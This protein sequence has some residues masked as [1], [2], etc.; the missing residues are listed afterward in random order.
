MDKIRQTLGT[1]IHVSI[2][3]QLLEFLRRPNMS[4]S[5]KY[6][7]TRSKCNINSIE[8]VIDGDKYSEILNGF[9]KDRNNYS[10]M[11]WMDGVKLTVFVSVCDPHFF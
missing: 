7:E 1:F 10:L 5:W 6:R 2:R 8:D 9:L 4:T 11:L 3:A